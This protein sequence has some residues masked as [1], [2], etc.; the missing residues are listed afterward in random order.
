MG[1]LSE[2]ILATFSISSQVG[3]SVPIGMDASLS[4]FNFR[5][6]RRRKPITLLQVFGEEILGVYLW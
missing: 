3:S 4:C 6:G 1:I 5:S 2:S